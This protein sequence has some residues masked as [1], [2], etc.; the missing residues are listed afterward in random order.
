MTAA[1]KVYKTNLINQGD[2][3]LYAFVSIMYSKAAE[4]DV[5][6]NPLSIWWKI[7]MGGQE[8]KQ[9]KQ[10]HYRKL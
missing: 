9:I 10:I 8:W 1:N 6:L 4:G 5:T 7:V 3:F 2:N